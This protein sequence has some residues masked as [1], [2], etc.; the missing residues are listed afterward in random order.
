M[1]LTQRRAH[2]RC[3]GKYNDN[4]VK[5][6]YFVHYVRLQPNK[7][8]VNTY[9]HVHRTRSTQERRTAFFSVNDGGCIVPV[10]LFTI[11]QFGRRCLS[12]HVHFTTVLSCVRPN[13]NKCDP[14]GCI[15]TRGFSTSNTIPNRV[16]ERRKSSLIQHS[17]DNMGHDHT[18]YHCQMATR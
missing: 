16:G 12:V 2:T 15:L 5:T 14:E 9:S 7:K 17:L 11:L 8:S 3:A 4:N 1:L 10:P 18:Y 13:A 6:I